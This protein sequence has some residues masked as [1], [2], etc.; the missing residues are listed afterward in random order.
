MKQNFTPYNEIKDLRLER[1]IPLPFV[2][3]VFEI[4]PEMLDHL[5]LQ[6]VRQ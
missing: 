3:E 1:G 2:L 4:L 6:G 5:V